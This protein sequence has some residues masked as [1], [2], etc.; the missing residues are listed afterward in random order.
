MA[1]WGTL[2]VE[3]VDAA[4]GVCVFRLGGSLTGSPSGFEFLETVRETVRSGTRRVVLNLKALDRLD[5][6]GVGIIASCYTSA[7]NAGGVVALAEVRERPRA[8]LQVVRL[9]TVIP[10][11][12]T[13]EAALA[14]EAGR[15]S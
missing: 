5:S 15:S 11:F 1:V 14:A 8:I 3:K 6:S 10:E 4:P 9:L 12:P 7:L 2:Q 13:E